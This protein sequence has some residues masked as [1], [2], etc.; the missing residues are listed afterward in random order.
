[1]GM[2]KF[3]L[4][5]NCSETLSLCSSNQKSNIHSKIRPQ[6]VSNKIKNA[7]VIEQ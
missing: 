2:G 5:Q 4:K 3:D 7:V 6:A 1:M